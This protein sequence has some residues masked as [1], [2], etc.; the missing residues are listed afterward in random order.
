MRGARPLT[1]DCVPELR[2]G[3]RTKASRLFPLR[4]NRCG[5]APSGAGRCLAG[6]GRGGSLRLEGEGERRELEALGGCPGRNTRGKP[7]DYDGT[8]EEEEEE[9]GGE[10]S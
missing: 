7:N 2:Y 8:S 9:E 5:A 1:V 4:R 10:Y 6:G 3:S